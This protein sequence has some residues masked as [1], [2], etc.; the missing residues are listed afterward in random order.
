MSFLLDLVNFIIYKI[1][2]KKFAIGFL[3]EN[4]K[5][6]PY[7]KDFIINKKKNLVVTS[8]EKLIPIHNKKENI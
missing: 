3:C 2:E 6:L 1:K 7:I 8:F 5:I 4:E